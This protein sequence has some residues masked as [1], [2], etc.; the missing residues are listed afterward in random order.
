MNYFEAVGEGVGDN[1]RRRSLP[2]RDFKA[3]AMQEGMDIE[4]ARWKYPSG[5]TFGTNTVATDGG[6]PGTSLAAVAA[7]GPGLIPLGKHWYIRNA[8][9]YTS[10]PVFFQIDSGTANG[11]FKSPVNGQLFYQIDN[12]AYSGEQLFASVQGSIDPT[13]TKIV[14][15][16]QWCGNSFSSDTNYGAKHKVLFIGDSNTEGTSVQNGKSKDDLYS[17]KFVNWLNDSGVS[18]R[19][20]EKSIGGKSSVHYNDY[21]NSGKLDVIDPSVIIYNLGTN[22]LTAPGAETASRDAFLANLDN[23]IAWKKSRYPNTILIVCS[24]FVASYGSAKEIWLSTYLRPG[25]ATKISTVNDSKILYCDFS[26]VLNS[27]Y[28][29]VN[30][31]DTYFTTTDSSSAGL[32]IHHNKAGHDKDFQVLRD[33]AISNGLISAIESIKFR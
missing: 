10:H 23:I 1:F 29:F 15:A 14:T 5:F 16:G 12:V 31:T 19:R 32:R 4:A 13:V 11:G 18:A 26:T 7:G 21:L 2:I 8:A 9:G 22:D 6:S 24:P 20:L 28:N 17:Q 33:F 25:I 30:S 3:I 27:P